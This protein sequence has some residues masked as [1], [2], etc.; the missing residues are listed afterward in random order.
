MEYVNN[1]LIL[2]I[3]K[4]DA[5]EAI[6][7]TGSLPLRW[8]SHGCM[9]LRCMNSGIRFTIERAFYNH[10]ALRGFQHVYLALEVT[11][12]RGNRNTFKV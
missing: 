3:N 5:R 12:F 2:S 8:S 1:A 6:V 9:P 11:E 4:I 10:T 7:S